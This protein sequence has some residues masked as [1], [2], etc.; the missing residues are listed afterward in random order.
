MERLRYFIQRTLFSMRQSPLLCSA[1]IGTVAIALMLLAFFTL[2]VLNIQN[3]TRE[4]SQ[5]IQVIVYLDNVP[6]DDKLQQWMDEIQQYP[7][8]EQV[9]YVSQQQAFDRFHKR[10]GQNA[11]LLEGLMPEILPAALEISLEETARSRAGTERL[12]ELLKN[13]KDF[14]NFRYGQEWLDRYDAFIFL[15]RLTGTMAGGFLIFATLFIISNTIKLTIYARRDELEIMGLIGATPMFIKAPFMAE[16][17]CQGV[18]G[19]LLALGGCHVLYYFF[20]KKGLAALLTTTAAENIHFLP[21][22]Y[23]VGIIVL[24][25]LLGFIGSVLPLRKFVRI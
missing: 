12:I 19:A 10:L 23:Q 15:L 7:D 3:L 18:A 24:G 1:T 17:A 14:H 11:D 13:N 5:D 6:S 21:I 20:L 8:I 16:G 9:R 4:W 2:I 22:E 25:L